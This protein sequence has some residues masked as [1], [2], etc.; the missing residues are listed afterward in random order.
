LPATK[1]EPS[2]QQGRQEL[3]VVLRATGP[4]VDGQLNDWEKADWARIDD[5][6]SGAVTF[7]DETLFAAWKTNDAKLLTNDGG[8]TNFLF[9]AGGALDL[10]IGANRL[11]DVNRRQPVEGD[12]RLLITQVKGRPRATLYRAVV[13]N[14]AEAQKVLFESPIGKVLFDEVR[15]VSSQIKLAQNGSDFE[16]SVPLALLGMKPETGVDILGDIGVLRGNGLQ[17]IQRQYWNNLNTAIVSDIPS[18]ALL[19]PRNWGTWKLAAEAPE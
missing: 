9:K 7:T 12:L 2:R 8:A 15:D 4:A 6:T 14:S 5:N 11:G 19:Q 17:T 10:M 16:I 1:T 18:E 13:P 3:Q